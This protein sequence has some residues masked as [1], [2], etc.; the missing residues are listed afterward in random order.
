[1][2]FSDSDCDSILDTYVYGN[3]SSDP[4]EVYE[5]NNDCN[6]PIQDQGLFCIDDS[7][8]DIYDSDKDPEYTPQ[9]DNILSVVNNDNT[10]VNDD[11]G[12][13]DNN[14]NDVNYSKSY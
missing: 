12:V 13:D 14:I 6:I 2:D 8:S 1:M 9:S 10:F 7:G 5:I 4:D 11:Y 3:M